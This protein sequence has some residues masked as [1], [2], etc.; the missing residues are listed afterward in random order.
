MRRADTICR[1]DGTPSERVFRPSPKAGALHRI[2][3][4]FADSVAWPARV[5]ARTLPS[6]WLILNR[7]AKRRTLRDRVPAVA[8]D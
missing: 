2:S 8:L 3:V 6:A 4:T 1:L 7:E 5:D